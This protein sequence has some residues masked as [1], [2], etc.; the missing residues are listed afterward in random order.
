VSTWRGALTEGLR[1]LAHHP[2]LAAAEV[3]ILVALP[4]AASWEAGSTL[5]AA[6]DELARLDQE[7]RTLVLVEPAAQ[8]APLRGAECDSLASAAVV[9]SAGGR[10]ALDDGGDP[11]AGSEHRRVGLTRGAIRAFDPALRLPASRVVLVGTGLTDDRGSRALAEV[12]AGADVPAPEV[13]AWRTP[14]AA[15]DLERAAVVE[16]DADDEVDT[17]VVRLRGEPEERS[18][19]VVEAVATQVA[20]RPMGA[21]WFAND[22]QR[23][24]SPLLAWARRPTRLFA[25]VAAGAAGAAL[26]ALWALRTAVDTAL[27]RLAGASPL[28]LAGASCVQRLPLLAV[29]VSA[30]CGAVAGDADT[31]W[32]VARVGGGAAVVV[33]VTCWCTASAL[34]ALRRP[35]TTL[36]YGD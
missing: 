6:R 24:A 26:G 14:S 12:V 31:R 32:T 17:C 29:G 13:I 25:T 11:G 16:L 33:S 22:E 3:A 7:G 34:L 9:R 5:A 2:V 15:G 10:R 28:Q 36:R 1:A 8:G 23:R 30:W 20:G 19:A 4:I 35:W 27:A 21:R 18:R